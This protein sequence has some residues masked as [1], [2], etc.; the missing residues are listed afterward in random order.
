MEVSP[1]VKKA[2]VY[3]SNHC[4]Y[5]DQVKNFLAGKGVA[6]EERNVEANE[7]YA[8]QLLDMGIRSVP[9]ILIGKHRIVGMNKL[10][11]NRALASS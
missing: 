4:P 2:I 11:I 7:T 3:T 6:I 8:R 10:D 1:S 9:L 5:C